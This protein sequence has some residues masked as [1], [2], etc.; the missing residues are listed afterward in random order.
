MIVIG[1]D[2]LILALYGVLLTGT[3]YIM[4]ALIPLTEEQGWSAII[5]TAITSLCY[6]VGYV[7]MICVLDWV[8]GII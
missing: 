8:L 5:A 7:V 3:A 2:L 1:I 4:A 6:V